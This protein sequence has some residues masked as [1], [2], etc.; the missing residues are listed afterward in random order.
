MMELNNLEEKDV[1]EL[2]DIIDY[3]KA[4]IKNKI[5]NGS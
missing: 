2:W 1:N 4:L 5:K 3:C